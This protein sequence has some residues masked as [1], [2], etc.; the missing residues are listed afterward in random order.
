MQ[1]NFIVDLRIYQLSRTNVDEVVSELKDK[2]RGIAEILKILSSEKNI[3]AVISKDLER[4]EKEFGDSRRSKVNS[5]YEEPVY[6]KES[7]VQHEDVFVI[8]TADGWIKRIRSNN[9]PTNTRIREGDS[10]AFALSASTKDTLLLLSNQGNAFG[11]SIFD[12]ASTSGFGEPVQKLFKF[13]DGEQIAYAKILTKNDETSK[14]KLILAS[15]EGLGFRY[16]ISQLGITKKNGKKIAKLK[17]GDTLS[18]VTGEDR[19]FVLC[20]SEQGYGV[21][22]SIAEIPE[23]TGGGKGVILSKLPSEDSLQALIC[24]DK[25]DAIELQM[26]QGKAHKVEFS[27]LTST[28]RAK[29]GLKVVKKGQ[30]KSAKRINKDVSDVLPLFK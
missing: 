17:A 13:A 30:V 16:P 28:G 10:I 1:A 14:Q 6:D 21:L 15:K 9:D 25:G 11:S 23:L 18:F 24:V 22:F 20:V 19:R 7:F 8:V 27:S 29:R 12:L 3:K 5:E 2:R 4:I 26:Q